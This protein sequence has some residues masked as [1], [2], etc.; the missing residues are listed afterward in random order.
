MYMIDFRMAVPY[1]ALATVKTPADNPPLKR[2]AL[3]TSTIMLATQASCQSQPTFTICLP[4]FLPETSMN[5][6]VCFQSFDDASADFSFPRKPL[7]SA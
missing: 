6:W 4:R 3:Y 2:Q 1:V 5:R 7:P